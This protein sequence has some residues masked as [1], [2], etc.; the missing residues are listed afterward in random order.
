MTERNWL[1]VYEQVE[2]LTI[3]EGLDVERCE[4]LIMEAEPN[5]E[6]MLVCWF[7]P[8]RGDWSDWI[9]YAMY[10]SLYCA[11]EA[12]WIEAKADV[13]AY[14]EWLSTTWWNDYV[15]KVVHPT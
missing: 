11:Y 10:Q 8:D 2:M 14:R 1:Q 13:D 6:E 12:E 5:L 9:D 7:D 3:P 4:D 15:L